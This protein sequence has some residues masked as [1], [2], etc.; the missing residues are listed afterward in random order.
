MVLIPGGELVMG[1]ENAGHES[2]THTV[3]LRAFL[4]DAREVTNGEYFKFCQ[5]T[6]RALP[7]FW[8]MREFRSGL[9]FPDH[10]VVGVSWHDALDYATWAGKRLPTEAEWEYAA[11][12]GLA[13]QPFPTGSDLAKTDANYGGSGPVRVGSFTSNG[14]GLHDMAGNA[15]EWVMDFYDDD[16]YSTS[17]A[18]NPT[19]PAKGQFCV[20]RG[21]GWKGGKMCA[22][23]TNRTALKP[24]W[25]DFAVGFRC[26]KDAP[27]P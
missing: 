26:A 9:D 12:G 16:Y 14:Y 11:R 20:V 19:G 27:K 15:A 4:L 5:A 25:V 24:Y 22:N 23:V 2:P 6:G 17:P 13:G 3:R 1:R 18:D 7:F 10:P 21:G 8:G